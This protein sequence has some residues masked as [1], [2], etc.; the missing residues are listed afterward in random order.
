MPFTPEGLPLR[1]TVS[2][3]QNFIEISSEEV[4]LGSQHPAARLTGLKLRFCG[5]CSVQRWSNDSERSSKQRALRVDVELFNLALRSYPELFRCEPTVTF[6]QHFL[7]L[8]AAAQT[9]GRQTHV[10]AR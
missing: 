3:V 7:S 6:E 2:Q 1:L 10:A 4:V 9:N 5:E 8:I